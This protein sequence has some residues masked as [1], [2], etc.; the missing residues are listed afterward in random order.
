MKEI[1]KKSKNVPK[2]RLQHIYDLARTKSI[3]EGG[4]GADK[5]HDDVGEDLDDMKPTVN[6]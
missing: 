5:N 2:R 1:I 4:G 3:C 6:I